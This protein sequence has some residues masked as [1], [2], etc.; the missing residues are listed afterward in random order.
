MKL[1]G[2]LPQSKQFTLPHHVLQIFLVLSYLHL[3]LSRYFPSGLRIKTMYTPSLPLYMPHA[4]PIY[5]YFILT[6]Q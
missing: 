5:F 2:S 1:K 4:L 3:G 6:P